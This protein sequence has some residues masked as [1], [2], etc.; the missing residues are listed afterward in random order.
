M[1]SI[2]RRKRMKTRDLLVAAFVLVALLFASGLG[3]QP[4]FR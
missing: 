1:S 2:L 4:L 3:D